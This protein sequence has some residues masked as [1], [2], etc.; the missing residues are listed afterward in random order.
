MLT[1]QEKKH[2]RHC[3]KTMAFPPNRYAYTIL[4]VRFYGDKTIYF[5][6]LTN[7]GMTQWLFRTVRSAYKWAKQQSN[8][9]ALLIGSVGNYR[10]WQ[11]HQIARDGWNFT[12]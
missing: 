9:G 11:N 5:R 12:D 3:Y 10:M 7:G 4:P 2:H 8:G 6:V 1:K